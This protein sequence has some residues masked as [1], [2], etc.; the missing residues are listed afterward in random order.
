MGW[1]RGGGRERVDTE[2]ARKRSEGKEMKK[3]AVRRRFAGKQ[4]TTLK[5]VTLDALDKP[6]QTKGKGATDSKLN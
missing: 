3:G 4:E 6:R 2:G 5:C 1:G